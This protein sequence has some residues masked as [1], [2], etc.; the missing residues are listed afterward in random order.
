LSWWC[1][2]SGPASGHMMTGLTTPGIATLSFSPKQT[3][4]NVQQ[5]CWDQNMNDLGQGKWV[6]VFIVP[7]ADIASHGGN[8]SYAAASG[9]PF[10]GIPRRLPAGAVDFTWLRGSTFVDKW[11]ANATYTET[12]NQWK[13]YFAGDYG[14]VGG[15]VPNGTLEAA[16]RFKICLNSGGNM[17]IQRPTADGTVVTESYP[18]GTTFPTGDVRVIFQDASYNPEKHSG[19]ADHLTWHFDNFA[20]SS[21]SAV[22]PASYTVPPAV[23][24][25]V[26]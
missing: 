8:F 7:A 20:V 14:N 2:P 10:G 18:I 11:G 1:A 26:L 9:L 6:N 16:P 15:M 24:Y 12:M 5:L 22:I 3:F 23:S 13:S 17:V 4:N 25:C 19:S 21:S